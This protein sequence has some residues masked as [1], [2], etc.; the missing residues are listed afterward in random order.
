MSIYECG[1]GTDKQTIEA[2]SAAVAAF[3]YFAECVSAN[4]PV[5]AIYT[6]N[7][8]PF[9]MADAWW[10]AASLGADIPDIEVRV[11]ACIQQF[12]QC[13]VIGKESA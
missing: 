9:D 10:I 13:R 3:Y 2:P 12:S 6:E 5:V 7:G 8:Q 1:M 11:Q 4:L